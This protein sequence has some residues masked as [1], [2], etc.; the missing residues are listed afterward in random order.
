MDILNY[1]R[2]CIKKSRSLCAELAAGIR[3]GCR[4]FMIKARTLCARLAAGIQNGCRTFIIKARAFCA[5]YV[6]VKRTDVFMIIAVLA[7]LAYIIV[8]HSCE[9]VNEPE[10]INITIS[11][12]CGDLFGKDTVS[13]LIQEFEEQNPHLRIQEA[14]AFAGDGADIVF[15][16]DSEYRSLINNT[17]LPLVSFMDL[18]I[19]NIDILQAANLDRPPKTRV[20]FLAAARAVTESKAASAFA[21][22]LNPADPLALRRDIYPWLWANGVDIN[23]IDLSGDAPAF[24]RALNDTIAFLGQL[25]RENLLAPGTFAATGTQ[26]LQEFTEGKIAMMTIS[27]RDIAFLRNNAHGITYGIT[28]LPTLT[29]GKNRLGLSGI[30]AGIS[31]DSAV[32]DEAGVFL[33]FLAK[34]SNVLAKAI[35]A[36]PGSYPGGLAGEYI[37]QDPVYSKAWEIFEAADII[38]YKPDQPSEEAFNILIREKLAEAFE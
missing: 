23:A 21:L 31:G 19:Y 30:Y 3:N 14:A 28:A 12:Q 24:P 7:V 2:K 33:S 26:R 37:M 11:S 35:G 1:C 17:A 18:F 13:A 10:R 32:L 15:F 38:E 34:K 4:A 9:T 5:E 16:D 29:Q 8:N 6:N 36:V 20:E 22:G 25:N 27:A